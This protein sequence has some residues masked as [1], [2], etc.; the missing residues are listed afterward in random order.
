[1]LLEKHVAIVTG[2]A[3]GIG[4]ATVD[5]MSEEGAA[6]VVADINQA[7]AEQVAADLRAKGR[8]ASA[9]EIDV[10]DE[11]RI[12][13]MIAFAVSEFGTLTILHNN[14]GPNELL[15]RLDNDLLNLDA[16]MWDRAMRVALRGAVLCSKYAIPVMLEKEGR[17]VIIN[18]SSVSGIMGG[19]HR[20]THQ[21]SKAGLNA[22]TK[23]IA[24]AHGDQGIRCN[25]ILP[26]MINTPAYDNM[27]P[28]MKEMLMTHTPSARGGLPDDIAY[29]AVFLASDRAGFI[30]GTLIPV[31][32][33]LSCHE[34]ATVDLRK[35]GV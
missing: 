7:G 9:F 4:M 18:T 26:G 28:N 16:E 1:M 20:M 34:P 6:V 35:M 22:L 5:R 12:K 24:T 32:G 29:L 2:S 10:A 15:A 30:N 21:M 33:G 25:A 19:H 23:A 11:D 13:E 17:G 8:K 14:A 27:P 31:D 3:S